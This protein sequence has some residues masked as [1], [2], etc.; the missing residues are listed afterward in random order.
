MRIL[1]FLA[2]LFSAS[3]A[4][5]AELAPP[6]V[7]NDATSYTV[8]FHVE[9]VSDATAQFHRQSDIALKQLGSIKGTENMAMPRDGGGY[10]VTY[11][12]IKGD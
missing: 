9:T 6:T 2:A 4:L 5:A 1:T 8:V 11:R 10:D 7:T 3:S 12:F